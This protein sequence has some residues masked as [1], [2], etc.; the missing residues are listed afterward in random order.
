MYPLSEG[1]GAH[2]RS[3]QGVRFDPPQVLGS[4]VRPTVGAYWLLA[5]HGMAAV[6]VVQE[7]RYY[8]YLSRGACPAGRWTDCKSV[9]HPILLVILDSMGNGAL[10]AW[11]PS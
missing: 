11:N 2:P 3:G 4:Y 9:P 5:T 6:L 10:L 1:G 8:L 7:Y